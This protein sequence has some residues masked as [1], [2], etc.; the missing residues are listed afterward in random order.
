MVRLNEGLERAA[1]KKPLQ[2]K[3][4]PAEENETDASAASEPLGEPVRKKSKPTSL[5]HLTPQSRNPLLAR[6]DRLKL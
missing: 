6:G 5:G 1:T 4:D 2:Y 3:E